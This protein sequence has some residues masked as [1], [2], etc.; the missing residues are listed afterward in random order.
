MIA[1]LLRNDLAR[2][3][4]P[5]S[6]RV[7]KLAAVES[8]ATVHQLVTTVRG[9]LAAG[10]DALDAVAAAFP[11]GSM[12]GAPKRRTTE[13]I[14]ALER[15]DRGAY[16]ALG[17]FA[18]NGAADLNVV[19]RTAVL[20]SLASRA[21]RVEIAAGG[22]LTALSDVADEWAEVTLKASGAALRAR[23]QVARPSNVT[24]AR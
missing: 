14:D 20:S 15:R 12:T 11:P 18:P 16:A 13:L 21:P 24:F 10:N 17:F 23:S 5:G 6:V 7:P 1:D 8:F 2:S 4:E 22:A 9:D 3:C 19:I